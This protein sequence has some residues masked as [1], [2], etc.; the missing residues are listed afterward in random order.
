MRH[1]GRLT[2]ALGLRFHWLL[3]EVLSDV[4]SLAS[5]SARGQLAAPALP[6]DLHMFGQACRIGRRILAWFLGGGYV[7]VQ[8]ARLRRPYSPASLVASVGHGC[9]G[10]RATLIGVVRLRKPLSD[11]AY[12]DF[13]KPRCLTVVQ[14]DLWSAPTNAV[15]L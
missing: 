14:A 9:A 4:S 7:G 13:A 11:S 3:R 15:I 10:H 5:A 8:A 2:Q 6:T 1:T 12:L